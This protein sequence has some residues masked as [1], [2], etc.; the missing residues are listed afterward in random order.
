MV[1]P[2]AKR[3]RPPSGSA[4]GRGA[5]ALVPSSRAPSGVRGLEVDEVGAPRDL[6]LLAGQLVEG[7]EHDEPR[8]LVGRRRIRASVG[9][10]LAVGTKLLCLAH[11][12]G[13]CDAPCRAPATAS[14]A[15]WESSHTA[16]SAVV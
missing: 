12:P 13:P 10:R 11:R 5:S 15:L 14:L 7:A 4:R 8:W 2:A 3:W 6:Q 9:R 16:W 1:P